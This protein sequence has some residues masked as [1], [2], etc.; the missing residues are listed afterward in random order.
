M[1]NT[2]F[3]IDHP[4]VAVKDFEQ[5]IKAYKSLGFSPSPV[6]YHPWGT[7][8]S[9]MM[10]KDNFIE[11][12]SVHDASKFGYN[13]VNGFCYG[14]NVGNFL[15][16]AEGLGLVALH[17]KD[18]DLDYEFLIE[19]GLEHQGRIDFKREIE[20]SPGNKD[21]AAVSLGLLLNSKQR[22]VSNFICHQHKPELIW[23][24]EWQ[25]HPNGV[26]NINSVI[27]VSDE[28][29]QLAERFTAI[30]GPDKVTSKLDS[31][32]VDSGCGVFHILS[33]ELAKETLETDTLPERQG[34]QS[35]GIAISMRSQNFNLLESLWP[36]DLKY[37][38]T[39]K[40]SLVVDYKYCGNVF[41]EFTN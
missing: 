28:P 22:D 27:Y 20:V 23:V 2:R 25:Q 16:R 37:H 19:H 38:K 1:L 41:L 29:I 4:V 21:I 6:S 7:V 30:Y 18:A 8:L 10:F 15:D 3:G 12:I 24:P 35:Y 5:T 9:L 39:K 13:E 33:P 36:E 31:V 40:G 34:S 32:S 26:N 17:S 11:V 14:R